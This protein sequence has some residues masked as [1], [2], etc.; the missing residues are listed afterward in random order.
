MTKRKDKAR[1]PMRHVR[2]NRR[3]QTGRRQGGQ[4]KIPDVASDDPYAD[5]DGT[6]EAL[7]E[8]PEVTDA[9]RQMAARRELE[10][11]R[12]LKRLNELLDDWTFM[13]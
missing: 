7:P 5:E 9:Q 1:E 8:V 13:E 6:W 3:A 2:T 4:E 12:E 10:M 11:R